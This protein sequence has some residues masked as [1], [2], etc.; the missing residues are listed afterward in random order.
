MAARMQKYIAVF[1]AVLILLIPVHVQAESVSGCGQPAE[2][3]SAA[4][5]CDVSA[6]EGSQAEPASDGEDFSEEKTVPEERTLSE[7]PVQETQKE[8]TQEEPEGTVKEPQKEETVSK[9]DEGRPMAE[10]EDLPEP[11]E[12]IK[13]SGEEELSE[14]DAHDKGEDTES[15]PILKEDENVLEADKKENEPEAGSESRPDKSGKGNIPENA[16]DGQEASKDG[17]DAS[18]DGEE[19]S[20][21]PVKPGLEKTE[22]EPDEETDGTQK[23]KSDQD[24]VEDVPMEEEDAEDFPVLLRGT[25]LEEEG[26]F[27][28]LPEGLAGAYRLSV[29]SVDDF[30]DVN[31]YP[32]HSDSI[33]GIT[34]LRNVKAVSTNS[35]VQA[36]GSRIIIPASYFRNGELERE[37]VLQDAGYITFSKCA[38]TTDGRFVDMTYVLDEISVTFVKV[39]YSTG[40]TYGLADSVQD[41]VIGSANTASGG[42]VTG[43]W[44]WAGFLR[45][46]DGNRVTSHTALPRTKVTAHIRLTYSGT[47]TPVQDPEM[48]L[49]ITD[50]DVLN[51][52]A[53]YNESMQFIS[54]WGNTFY[55]PEGYGDYIAVTNGN[56]RYTAITGSTDES[57]RLAAVTGI[58]ANPTASFIWRGGGLCGTIVTPKVREVPVTDASVQKYI[59][60]VSGDTAQYLTETTQAYGTSV[61]YDIQMD[62]PNAVTATAFDSVTL[63]DTFSPMVSFTADNVRMW[64]DGE[65]VTSNWEIS[66][67]ENGT[68][69]LKLTA[70]MRDTR[71][72]GT[73]HCRLAAKITGDMEG[74]SVKKIGGVTYAVI[75]NK[76]KLTVKPKNAAKKGMETQTVYTYVPGTAVR[77]VKKADQ[78]SISPAV[79]GD[80]IRYTF[81]VKNTGKFTLRDV[82]FTD[83]LPVNDLSFDWAGSSDPATG[84]SV[85]SADET[86]TGTASYTVTKADIKRGYVINSATVRGKDKGGVYVED[87]DEVRTALSYNAAISLRKRPTPAPGMAENAKPGDLITYR[88]VGKNT[89]N[90]PLTN[91]R[92][93]DPMEGLSEISYDWSAASGEGILA[94]GEYV[95]GTATYAI[96]GADILAGKKDNTARIYGTDPVDEVVENTWDA[97]VPI[98]SAPE[99]EVVKDVLEEMIEDPKVGDI[100]HYQIVGT[101]KGYVTLNT[102]TLADLLEGKVELSLRPDWSGAAAEGTLAP[103]EKV[104]ATAEYTITQEDIDRGTVHNVVTI[105]GTSEK[106]VTVT[107]EDDADTVLVRNPSIKVTKEA[108]ETKIVNAKAGDVIHYE[109]L[110]T[111]D[112]NV[113]LEE[114]SL[115]DLL[116][117]ELELPLELDWSEAAAEGT[118]APGET[119]RAAAEYTITKEDIERGTVHNVVTIRG[120]SRDGTTVTDED[121]ADTVLLTP[122]RLYAGGPGRTVPVFAGCAGLFVLSFLYLARRKFPR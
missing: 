84:S 81:D 62:L 5:T 13:K 66:V 46:A 64:R 52:A 59:R 110:G 7:E 42:D 56:S 60:K 107:D 85:L 16:K 54:G 116:E 74:C 58:L 113:T 28:S 31:S 37:R 93:E 57:R 35:H 112:G 86:L 9:T 82:Q 71:F 96:T 69:G 79:P 20:K 87:S 23:A 10:K 45:D 12:E 2:T 76:A 118:L 121:D 90:V 88:F 49:T 101:N 8:T 80:V 106:G 25:D 103:G 24:D 120:T 114:V 36:S 48:L 47:D 97:S 38:M 78:A 32:T 14:P 4:L 51:A 102:V 122:V 98:G 6:G 99:I 39:T 19:A 1:M 68:A 73:I 83:T 26:N 41:V 63:E 34:S 105:S 67:T 3:Q 65:N 33:I 100:I 21:L 27:E 94:P 108:R 29:K 61:T 55:V 75:P 115:F 30:Y 53:E 22:N 17:T 95:Y 104:R 40:I 44:F 72:G 109:I 11:G 89:G 91:V 111:N 18:K 50:L 77:L 15:L 43:Y 119:V 117:G 70:A 92:I